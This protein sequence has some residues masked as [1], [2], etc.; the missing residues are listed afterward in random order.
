MDDDEPI[1]RRYFS[2][3]NDNLLYPLKNPMTHPFLNYDNFLPLS[4][5]M[6]RRY[7]IS[8]PGETTQYRVDEVYLDND[9]IVYKQNNRLFADNAG[10]WFM[11]EK[12]DIA[13]FRIY[14]TE[15]RRLWLE[16]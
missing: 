11:T 10:Q 4:E 13:D 7:H 5:Y 1:Y 12:R 9:I 8:P 6:D 16:V 14:L 15:E 3:I 2:M